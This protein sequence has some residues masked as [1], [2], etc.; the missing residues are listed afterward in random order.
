MVALGSKT[1][2]AKEAKFSAEAR[3]KMLRGV[4][5]LANAVKVTLGP[6][7][8]NVVIEKSFGAPLDKETYAFGYEAQTG[9][10]GNLISKATTNPPK[11]SPRAPQTPPPVPDLL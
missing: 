2:A 10:F 9:E 6:K 8:R 5:I 4:D 11:L 3:E 1:M 7:G